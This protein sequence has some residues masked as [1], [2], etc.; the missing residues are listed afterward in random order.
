MTG[1]GGSS[2]FVITDVVVVDS[3][4]VVDFFGVVVV[5]VDGFTF[6]A[7]RKDALTIFSRSCRRNG[8]IAVVDDVDV[9]H[10]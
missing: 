1:Q 2:V 4:A 7:T 6:V 5:I 10:G 8:I 9:A 3:V